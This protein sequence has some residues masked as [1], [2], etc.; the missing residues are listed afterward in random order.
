MSNSGG[1]LVIA[2]KQW[3][4][5]GFCKSNISCVIRGHVVA[6]FPDSRQKQVMR[7]TGNWKIAEVFYCLKTPGCAEFSSKRITTKDLGNFDIEQARCMKR[8]LSVEKPLNYSGSRRRIEQHLDQGRGVYNDHLR[9]L[10][11]LTALA[12]G[13]L[14]VTRVR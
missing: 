1:E 6:E 3:C 11:T 5:K 14:V 4:V 7:I 12:G 10:S 9:S 8:F 13:T 2:R